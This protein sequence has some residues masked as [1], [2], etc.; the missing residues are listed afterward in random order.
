MKLL[1]AIKRE[2]GMS[3]LTPESIAAL[4]DQ[5]NADPL[6]GMGKF[7]KKELLADRIAAHWRICSAQA[8]GIPAREIKPI[9]VEAKVN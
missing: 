9:L 4:I 7:S 5:I 1:E 8:K 6:A 2:T 3:E